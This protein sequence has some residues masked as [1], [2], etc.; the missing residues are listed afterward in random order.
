MNALEVI[1]SVYA[2]GGKLTVDGDELRVSAPAPLPDSLRQALREHKP[3]IMVVLGA[4]LDVVVCKVLAELRQHLP[5]SLQ[6][7]SDEK[8]LVLVNW[9]I[10]AAWEK[11]GQS[12]EEGR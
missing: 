11:A 2:Y 4:P 7:L 6:Q 8:L 3:S 12:L 5:Q 10:M 1:R 9:T